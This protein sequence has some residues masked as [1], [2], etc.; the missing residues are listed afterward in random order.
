MPS[1][2]R[3]VTKVQ[4]T[5]MIPKDLDP[6]LNRFCADRSVSKSEVI[7]ALLE[8]LREGGIDVKRRLP[9]EAIVPSSAD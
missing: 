3:D 2:M 5:F 6:W 8:R 9:V 1:D 4:R 7:G